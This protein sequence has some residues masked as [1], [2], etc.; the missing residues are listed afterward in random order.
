MNLFQL[1]D[2]AKE[3]KAIYLTRK[4]WN[5]EKVVC[6][7]FTNM[8]HQPFLSVESSSDEGV[9]GNTFDECD[10]GNRLGRFLNSTEATLY[11]DFEV[12]DY[13][14]GVNL[15]KELDQEYQSKFNVGHYHLVMSANGGQ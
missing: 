15:F 10:F 7:M 14:D 4:E 3:N 5:G 1:Q 11:D 2:L 8:E 13:V 9:I 6:L 12:L